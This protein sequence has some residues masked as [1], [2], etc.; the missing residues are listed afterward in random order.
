[1]FVAAS[2]KWVRDLVY[3]R[4]CL[5]GDKEGV[6]Q[7]L[8]DEVAKECRPE[9]Q[10]WQIRRQVAPTQSHQS[11]G[12]AEKAVSTVRGPET[13]IPSFEVTTH[14]SMASVDDQTRSVG[15]HLMQCEKRHTN[16]PVREDSWT[17]NYRKEIPATG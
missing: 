17:E 3:E 13:K 10:D 9:G 7:M 6:L 14:S 12:V 11:N 8:L 5:H 15:S 2:A 1:M 16:D 4:F